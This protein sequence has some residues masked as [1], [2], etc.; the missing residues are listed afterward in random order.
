VLVAH[1]FTE[2]L[3]QPGSQLLAG[4]V[5]AGDPDGLADKPRRVMEDRVGAAADVLGGDTREPRFAQRR[6]RLFF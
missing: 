3:R 2:H 5:L 1:R 6:V 4:E